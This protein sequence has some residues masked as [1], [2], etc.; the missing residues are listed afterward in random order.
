MAGKRTNGTGTVYR[1]KARGGWVG[2]LIVD[3][4]R[5]RKVRARTR[6]E[7]EARL[8]ALLRQAA[9]GIVVD[10]NATVGEMIAR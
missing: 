3:D 8:T 9:K 2:Q 10:G 4:G 5:R 7:V 1:D 6:V